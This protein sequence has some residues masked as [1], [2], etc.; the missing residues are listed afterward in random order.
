MCVVRQVARKYMAADSTGELSADMPSLLCVA[1]AALKYQVVYDPVAQVCPRTPGDGMGGGSGALANTF[2]R[3][4][5]TKFTCTGFRRVSRSMIWNP[6]RGVA[7]RRHTP[8]MHVAS[9]SSGWIASALIVPAAFE[10][11]T[12]MLRAVELVAM[13]S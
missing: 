5:R 7:A 8:A 3:R 2:C 11:Q 13:P 1:V 6:R 12:V 9:G 10:Q 4:G